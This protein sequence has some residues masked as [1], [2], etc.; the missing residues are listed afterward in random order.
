MVF[1]RR[2]VLTALAGASSAL[3]ASPALHVVGSE[4]WPY[5]RFGPGEPT[6]LYFDLL[7]AAAESARWPLRFTEVPAARAL[8][9]LERGDADAMIGPIRTAEREKYL[10][11][12]RV[13]LPPEDKVIYTLP[14]APKVEGVGDLMGR[15]LGV[16]L[17]KR[18]GPLIDDNPQLQ[19]IELS[20][21]R[22]ALTLIQLG[23]LDA[24]LVPERQG[25]ALLQVL[26]LPLHKQ[27]FRITGETPHLVFSKRSAWLPRIQELE[28]AFERLHQSGAWNAAL[29]R[30]AGD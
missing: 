27:P 13:T 18:Y 4:D 23:R 15:R 25:D 6:G 1:T 14:S 16:Q 22:A 21:Y 9:M 29:Q 7:R 11:Y 24:A 30:Y 12:S 20:T 19:R 3:Q 17:G 10:H 8:L 26:K 5:R 2:S 28:A